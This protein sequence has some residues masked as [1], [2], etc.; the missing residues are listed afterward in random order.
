VNDLDAAKTWARSFAQEQFHLHFT[1][2]EMEPKDAP[3]YTSG[4]FF[5]AMQAA[6]MS[7]RHFNAARAVALKTW[8]KMHKEWVDAALWSA[9]R[10][11]GYYDMYDYEQRSD[12]D[13]DERRFYSQYDPQEYDP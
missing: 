8:Q 11:F 3:T 7:T 9:Q 1:H 5:K 10:R 13:D 2:Y 4:E 6:D 12:Y